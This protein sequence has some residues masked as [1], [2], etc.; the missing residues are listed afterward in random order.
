M[1]L[2]PDPVC[3]CV[4]LLP[5]LPPPPAA[6][7]PCPSHWDVCTTG[8]VPTAWS[9]PT[10]RNSSPTALHGEQNTV[11]VIAGCTCDCETDMHCSLTCICACKLYLYKRGLLYAFMNVCVCVSHLHLNLNLCLCVCLYVCL[12]AFVSAGG[13]TMG[14][15]HAASSTSKRVSRRQ[16]LATTAASRR[17]VKRAPTTRATPSAPAQPAP[18]V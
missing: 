8:H 15:A 2:E 18:L 7:R 16:A 11:A 12:F 5:P 4:V 9:L 10:T 13:Q 1:L 3:V 6:S 17:P 14:T